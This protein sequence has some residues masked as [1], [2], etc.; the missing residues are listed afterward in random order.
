MAGSAIS[1]AG[2]GGA[3]L[4]LGVLDDHQDVKFALPGN[5]INGLVRRR[6]RKRLLDTTL[7]C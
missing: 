1:A 4:L 7:G 2:R 3:E 5:E 6:L